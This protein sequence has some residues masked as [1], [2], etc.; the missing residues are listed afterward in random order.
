MQLSGFTHVSIHATDV[1]ESA[2]F[3]EDLFDVEREPAP[4]FGLPVVWLRFGDQQLHLF[5]RD[6]EAPPY[7]HFGVA[8]D[9]F[10]EFYRRARERGLLLDEDD[11]QGEDV[12]ELP[13]G[14]VQVYVR[15]PD[16]NLLEV[17]YPD[18]TD[19]DET[20]RAEVVRREDQFPQSAH[21]R[22]ATLFPPGGSVR[23]D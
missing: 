3:Y 17:D 9:D 18:V 12:Y 7:H 8:V 20:L 5:E 14:S 23:S 6:V 13:D 10:G 16:G 1:E 21:N 4:N 2:A 15:D 19:L 22:S 11:P